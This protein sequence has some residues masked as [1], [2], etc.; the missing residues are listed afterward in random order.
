MTVALHEH[1]FWVARDGSSGSYVERKPEREK[2]KS[3]GR[4]L[5][6]YGRRYKYVG[7]VNQITLCKRL[8]ESEMDFFKNKNT[9]LTLKGQRAPQMCEYMY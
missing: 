1:S 9:F 2:G 8:A 4:Y 7:W 6:M 5:W 3:L